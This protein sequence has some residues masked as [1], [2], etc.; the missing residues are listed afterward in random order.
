M[1]AVIVLF[2]TAFIIPFSVYILDNINNTPL[3]LI[4]LILGCPTLAFLAALTKSSEYGFSS[5][6]F[7][8]NIKSLFE[9]PDIKTENNRTKSGD[10]Y[11]KS[12][13]SG[14]TTP[15]NGKP[16]T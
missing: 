5:I 1:I 15:K 4:I 8:K 10:I 13:K 16:V 11:D 7:F 2:A 14:G 9:K 6:K 12:E 3:L